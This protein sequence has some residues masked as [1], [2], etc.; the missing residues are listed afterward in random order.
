MYFDE[1]NGPTPNLDEV[2][3]I[4]NEVEQT[5]NSSNDVDE[6]IESLKKWNRLRCEIGTW[7]SLVDLKN[8][9]DTTNEEYKAAKDE[10][11]E[12][13]P[14]L[15]EFRINL[16]KQLVNHPM[17]PELEARIKPQAFKLWESEIP[18]FDPQIKQDLID[19]QKLK[20]RYN[21]L[22]AAAKIEFDGQSQN[23]SSMMKYQSDS[24]RKKRQ[25]AATLYW[26]WF[27]A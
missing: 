3:A 8:C 21:D 20:N 26:N 6:M 23:L 9:Q 11:D 1:V 14:T 18:T 27:A 24:D 13:M 17:R 15:T 22:T 12:L 10:S 7:R 5:I 4:Y 16:I 2:K 19:E 25:E